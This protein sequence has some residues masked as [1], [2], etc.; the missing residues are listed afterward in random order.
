M[1]RLG[2]TGSIG[3]GKSTTAQMFRE[4]G[5]PVYDADAAVHALYAPGGGG[6]EALDAD[7]PEA[8]RDGAVD[9]GRLSALVLADASALGRLEALIHPLLARDR[10]AFLAAGAHAPLLAFD[11]PLLFET[12]GEGGVDAVA[13]VSCPPAE[14]RRRVLARPDMSEAK[15]E[16]ILRRQLPDAEKRRRADFVI[17]TG[18]G[19][20]AARREVG[21]IV[22][23][24]SD[25]GWR[26]ARP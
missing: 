8:V 18:R 12:G 17:E 10:A 19:L 9:R 4:A 24:L 6:S 15:F 22:Q 14:Q 5:V 11:V 7:F 26:R 21:R 13:V 3:M 20:E 2:L 16:A 23:L 25:P 1:I